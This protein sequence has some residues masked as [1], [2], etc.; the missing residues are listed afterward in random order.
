MKKFCTLHLVVHKAPLSIIKSKVNGDDGRF[1]AIDLRGRI[2]RT[3][4]RG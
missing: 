2:V 3:S 4:D 1:P